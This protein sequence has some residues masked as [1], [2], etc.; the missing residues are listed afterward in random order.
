MGFE[1]RV[2][3]LQDRHANHHTT[4][5]YTTLYLSVS[6]QLNMV[7]PAGLITNFLITFSNVCTDS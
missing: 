1:P 4:A 7:P 3:P 2:P 5:G 6:Q